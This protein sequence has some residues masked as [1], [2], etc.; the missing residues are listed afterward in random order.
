LIER[1]VA[2]G[3]TTTRYIEEGRGPV[4]VLL[5]GATLGC[6]ADDWRDIIPLLAA[7]GFRAV[8]YDQPGFGTNEDPADH[9]LAFRQKFVLGIL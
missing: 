4:I 6:S 2:V 5:H 9:S 3:G 7:C 1:T 8:A